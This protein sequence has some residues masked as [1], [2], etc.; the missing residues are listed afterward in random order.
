MNFILCNRFIQQWIFEGVCEDPYEEFFIHYSE[1]YTLNRN[2][3]FWNKS[4]KMINSAVPGFLNGIQNQIFQCGKA[5][6]LLKLCKP[7]V[8]L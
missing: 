2:R 5:V 7:E 1:H 3:K 4:F 8:N 6:H